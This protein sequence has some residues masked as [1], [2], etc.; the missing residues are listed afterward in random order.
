M[1]L[2]EAIFS[3]LEILEK[4]VDKLVS[5]KNRELFKTM[6]LSLLSTILALALFVAQNKL[7]QDKYSDEIQQKFE[8]GKKTELK[9]EL[10]VKM[11]ELKNSFEKF[12]FTKTNS[13]HVD[14]LLSVV[15][16][17][18]DLYCTLYIKQEDKMQDSVRK[19][20]I[21]VT[22]S[23]N[24]FENKMELDSSGFPTNGVKYYS[25]S[26]SNFEISIRSLQKIN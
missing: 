20:V 1:N 25:I 22:N 10:L 8:S 24:E 26:K 4:K 9:Y 12:C 18:S 6:S 14:S 2:E 11:I 17:L 15:T 21:E 16:D 23:H 5:L 7:T 19:F 13:Q 3:R